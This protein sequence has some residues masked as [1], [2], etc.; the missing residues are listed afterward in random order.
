VRATFSQGDLTRS[1]LGNR[2]GE[3]DK[4][5][6]HKS[7][8]FLLQTSF[9][10]SFLF[11]YLQDIQQLITTFYII[12]GDRYPGKRIKYSNLSHFKN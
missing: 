2:G 6:I 4:K 10:G 1:L 3:E 11:F 5:E 7:I 9:V 12:M 8:F